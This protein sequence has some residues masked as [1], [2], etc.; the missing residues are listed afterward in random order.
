MELAV[1]ATL[2]EANYLENK[3]KIMKKSKI[4]GE[5]TNILDQRIILLDGAMGTELQKF[6]LGESDFRGDLF[7]D[8]DV[9]LKGNN[10]LLCLTKPKVIQEVYQKYIDSGSDIIS[11]NSFNAS[12]ISQSEYDTDGYVD[13]MNFKAAQL[14]RQVVDKSSRK[15]YIAGSM[16]PMSRSCSMSPKAEQP[17]YRNIDFQQ[18]FESRS[19][20]VG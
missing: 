4:F 11:T 13:E 1:N 19:R 5:L 7:K 9:D 6:K 15:V 10:D 20:K 8:H 17:S 14:A 16:G 18:A 12:S 3:I 2:K